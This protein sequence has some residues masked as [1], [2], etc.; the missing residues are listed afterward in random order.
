MQNRTFICI[1]PFSFCAEVID[2]LLVE[3]I[4]HNTG[5]ANVMKTAHN[6]HIITYD[7]RLLVVI[8]QNSSKFDMHACYPPKYLTSHRLP[9]LVHVLG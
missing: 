2:A 3:E 8:Q 9:D 6:G 1:F 7:I 4:L 5:S